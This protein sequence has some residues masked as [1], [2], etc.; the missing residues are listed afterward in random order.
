MS[1]DVIDRL[2]VY[3]GSVSRSVEE[4]MRSLGQTNATPAEP[5]ASKGRKGLIVLETFSR[6]LKLYRE[7]VL[8]IS[9]SKL[10]DTLQCDHSYISRLEGAGRAPSR[11][12]IERIVEITRPTEYWEQRLYVA[13]GFLPS[14]EFSQL[15][16]PEGLRIV[17][18]ALRDPYLSEDTRLAIMQSVDALAA[19]VK[20]LVKTG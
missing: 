13:G 7:S 19:T 17:R 8:K 11:D 20:L 6:D 4:S 18:S 16:D 14:E 9:Q 10:A 5:P 3:S 15:T 2:A 1:T 12:F